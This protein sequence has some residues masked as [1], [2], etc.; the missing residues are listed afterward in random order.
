M[1]L[2]ASR[3]RGMKDL[4]PQE[5]EK[6]D[7]IC[8]TIKSE[9][10]LYGFKFIRTPVLEHTELF[11]RSAGDGS[12]IVN[13]E[14]YTFTDK[15]GR[16]VTLRPEG[17]AG[18]MRAVLEN[19]LHNQT[20]PLKLMYNSSC[21]RYEKPQIGRYREFFQFGLEV[22]G[23]DS[24]LAEVELICLADSI[25]KRIGIKDVNLE[26]NSIG[27]L[28][29]R[30]NYVKAIKDYFSER[31]KSLCETCKTRLE[32]NTLRI[33]DC[34]DPSCK[35]IVSN[36]PSVRDYLCEECKDHFEYIQDSLK[37]LGIDYKLNPRIVRGLDYYSRTVF[38][39]SADIDGNSV[40]IC[41]GGRYDK[42]SETFGGPAMPALG[43]G[44]GMERIFMVIE[45]QKIN[46]V[47]NDSPEVYIATADDISRLYA[48]KLCELLRKA[49]IF[50]ESDLL[51]RSLK[52]Q[53]KYADKVG[54][55]YT[56]FLGQEELEKGKAKI[57]E[58][59]TKKEYVI[60]ID[61]R[62]MD[63]FLSVQFKK[64]EF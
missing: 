23:S 63:D 14:M 44:I 36:A 25:L 48:L 22:F 42:L 55:N 57:R 59:N 39:F 17:T 10:R 29:C 16:S 53:L 24:P 21:Y 60:S 51:K 4:L 6:W 32:N 34:K 47:C 49:S 52:S 11:E 9:A 38:E 13:K 2:I 8:E 15:G 26:I 58:M 12:D 7:T 43:L 46:F 56:I 61:D 3:V 5:S 1:R 27:C 40:V 62:F 45:H 54:A 20:L 35:E 50:A 31:E 19:G 18:V 28:E 30:K 64:F 37:S 33:L 41:G